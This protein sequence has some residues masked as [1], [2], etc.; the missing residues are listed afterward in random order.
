MMSFQESLRKALQGRRTDGPARGQ[1]GR[2]A[3]RPSLEAIEE[4]LL[5]SGMDLDP[6]RP[7]AAVKIQA[8]GQA[9]LS[10]VWGTILGN[11]A[12]LSARLTA[13]DGSPISGQL[14]NFRIGMKFV[15]SAKTD[16][17]GVASLKGVRLKNLEIRSYIARTVAVLPASSGF[18]RTVSRGPL[19]LPRTTPTPTATTLDS[20]GA[21][22]TYGGTV[23]YTATLWTS[24]NAP[25]SGKSISFLVGNQVIGTATT[26]ASGVAIFRGSSPSGLNA[27]SYALSAKFAGD[28]GTAASDGAGILNVARATASLSVA[29]PTTTYNGRPVTASAVTLPAGLPVVYSYADAG[30]HSVSAPTKA[31]VYQVSAT[32]NDPNYTGSAL[33]SIT[34]ARATLGASGLTASDK[35]YDG[36]TTASI[37][38]AG[39]TLTGI[40]P[41]DSVT[42]DVSA[43]TAAF[44]SKAVGTNQ[45]ATITGL[46]LSG[47]DAGNYTLASTSVATTASIMP[48][49]VAATGITALDKVYDG[50]TSVWLNAGGANLS[51]VVAGDTVGLDTTGA[52]G[53]FLT[54]G[55]GQAKAVGIGGL[56]LTGIDAGNYTLLPASATA[57]VTPR[58][59]TVSGVIALDKVYDG[60]NV[61]S[62]DTSVASIQGVI[63]GDSVSLDTTAST[64]TFDDKNVNSDKAVTIDGLVLTGPDAATVFADRH[65]DDLGQH[66]PGPAHDRRHHRRQGLRRHRRP[67]RSRRHRGDACRRDRGATMSRSTCPPSPPTTRRWNAGTGKDVAYSGIA[68]SGADAGNYTFTSPTV[69]GDIAPKSVMYTFPVFAQQG[70]R[71]TATAPPCSS[72]PADDPEWIIADAVMVSGACRPAP[73]ATGMSGWARPSPSTAWA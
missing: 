7:V 21:G 42:I 69:T 72:R 73:S 23:S 31:G 20:V 26:D 43:A 65:G 48:R 29:G 53:A 49:A 24:N 59:V 32:I 38:T 10:G 35:V 18:P 2:R 8:A 5:L 56:S 16:A 6:L 4:R 3:A 17:D 11:R 54:K 25:V 34:I 41:G 27:G 63:A 39:A 52:F 36:T 64:G 66:H 30:G 33:G 68:V 71:R 70:L 58:G 44:A 12:N 1:A 37:N 57:S 55:A 13:D 60:T 51:G 28:A 14:I 9:H 62:L 46:A 50:N 19:A 40:V 15:G 45:P 22:G 67:R 47:A 61:A